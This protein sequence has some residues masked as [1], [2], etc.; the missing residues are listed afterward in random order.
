ML[1]PSQKQLLFQIV[2]EIL[3]SYGTSN[4]G[5]KRIHTQEEEAD[6]PYPDIATALSLLT[7]IM[8]SEF[9]DFSK[10]YCTNRYNNL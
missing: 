7:N 9:E 3:K 10:Y 5:K 1:E 4:R 8:A 6:R 2:V